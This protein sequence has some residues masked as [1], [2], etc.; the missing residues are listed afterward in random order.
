M[1]E[2]SLRTLVPDADA[3]AV[4]E[5]ISDF[6]R[7][8]DYTDAVREVRVEQ[9]DGQFLTSVWSVN[10]RNGVL[11]WTE[12]DRIDP[13]ALEI[14]FEQTAGDF[15]AFTGSWRVEQVDGDVAVLFSA[16][17]DLGMPTLAAIIDP[18]A[19]Q[20]LVDNIQSILRGLLG[21]TVVFGTDGQAAL[22]ATR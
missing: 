5:R 22:A 10:F 4:F 2:T 18:I 7:Y 13:R 20:A 16:A 11:C 14:E 21:D 6:P 8:A 17:F 1:R 19:E 15:A 3:T 9:R 12:R